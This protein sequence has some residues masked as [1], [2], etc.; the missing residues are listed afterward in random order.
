MIVVNTDGG[1]TMQFI[2]T[3]VKHEK[4]RNAHYQRSMSQHTEGEAY[5][6]SPQLDC[7]AQLH[8]ASLAP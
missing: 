2:D 6:K 1:N 3:V 8:C 4:C 7:C 5:Q